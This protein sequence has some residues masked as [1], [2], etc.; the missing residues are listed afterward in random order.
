MSWL[1]N[2]LIDYDGQD[3]W[4]IVARSMLAVFSINFA[5]ETTGVA[6]GMALALAAAG[7]V[8]CYFL[9]LLNY[10][11][12]R[13]AKPL[14]IE[15]LV[16]AYLVE[17]RT[18]HKFAFQILA[19]GAVIIL[20]FV[21]PFEA[22]PVQAAILNHRLQS[23]VDNPKSDPGGRKSISLINASVAAKIPIR[24][25]LV[26]KVS[27][28]VMRDYIY[29]AGD[30]ADP[31]I[32]DAYVEEVTKQYDS[33]AGVAPEPP[34]D[35]TIRIDHLDATNSGFVGATIR[36]DG[37]PLELHGVYF[38]SSRFIIA[39]NANGRKFV[40]TL[41]RSPNGQVDFSTKVPSSTT[42]R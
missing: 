25:S 40:D 10:A 32:W 12:E 24:S 31:K 18:S 29:K 19:V 35:N 5:L 21:L 9:Q 41:S 15:S 36:Y 27:P 13:S 4:R 16:T 42:P 20:A 23:F 3:R 30:D 11:L 6:Q 14:L 1:F 8:L 34:V 38:P 39:N 2:T 28:S 26:A 17:S 7:G 33:R 22:V 37:G